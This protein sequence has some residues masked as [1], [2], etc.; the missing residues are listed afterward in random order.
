MPVPSLG[1]RFRAWALRSSNKFAVVDLMNHAERI[2]AA[3][4]SLDGTQRAALDAGPTR[5]VVSKGKQK[6][7]TSQTAA[8]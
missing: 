8:V 6:A 5:T 2:D 3:C 7:T 1:K 4:S